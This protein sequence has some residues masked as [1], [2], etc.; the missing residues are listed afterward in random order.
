MQ[1]PRVWSDAIRGSEILANWFKL[2]ANAVVLWLSVGMIL[3]GVIGGIWFI[4]GTTS[5]ERKLWLHHVRNGLGIGG[6]IADLPDPNGSGERLQVP[7]AAVQRYTG[8]SFETV[9]RRFQ[10]SLF[11]T[12]LVAV[13][14]TVTAAYFLRRSGRSATE[15]QHIRGTTIAP[16][17]VVAA[18]AGASGCPTTSPL[19][20]FRSSAR[21]RPITSLR[22]G[23]RAAERG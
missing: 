3:G 9:S 4:E 2:G 1:T 15:D 11:L 14:G 20:A 18:L 23:H 6:P 21:P 5:L 8:R 7:K 12:F 13:A 17:D 16:P 22:A 10:E 19:L